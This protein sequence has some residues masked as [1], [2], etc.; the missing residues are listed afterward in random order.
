MRQ[1]MEPRY[2]MAARTGDEL[3]KREPEVR[4]RE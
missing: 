2:L 3:G 1:E 4:D